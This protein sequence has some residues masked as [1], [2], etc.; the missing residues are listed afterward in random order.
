MAAAAPAAPASAPAGA[1]GAGAAKCCSYNSESLKLKNKTSELF[2]YTTI[3][4]LLSRRHFR[5]ISIL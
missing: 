4:K 2:I 3:Q 1:A 5:D